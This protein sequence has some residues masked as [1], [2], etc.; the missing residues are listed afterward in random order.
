MDLG[1]GIAPQ[2][3][4]TIIRHLVVHRVPVVVLAIGS[5]GNF[6]DNRRVSNANDEQRHEVHGN[7]TEP[8][9][10]QLKRLVVHEGVERYALPKARE[11]RMHLHLEEHALRQGI[12]DCDEPSAEQHRLATSASVGDPQRIDYGKAAVQGDAHEHVGAQVETKGAQKQKHFARDVAGFP[13]DSQSPS[14]L[15]A[16]DRSKCLRPV[17][18][19]GNWDNPHQMCTRLCAEAPARDFSSSI[20]AT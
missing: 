12:Q 4:R 13:L 17:D 1:Q 9:V 5:I 16:K 15:Q 20:V 7:Q 19:W 11:L 8:I 10:R 14:N 6:A 18:R 3:N 2:H